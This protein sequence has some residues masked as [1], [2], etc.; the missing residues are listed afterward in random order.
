[1]LL[2]QN[3][4]SGG[5]TQKG[6]DIL[7]T[8]EYNNIKIERPWTKFM[9]KCIMCNVAGVLCCVLF[10]RAPEVYLVGINVLSADGVRE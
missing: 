9:A 1:M 3:C 5:L 4:D 8:L 2:S 10:V 6:N 7:H